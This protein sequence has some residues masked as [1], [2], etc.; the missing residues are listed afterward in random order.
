MT[1]EDTINL[2][3]ENSDELIVATE[4]G[5]AA[6]VGKN[7]EGRKVKISTKEYPNIIGIDEDEITTTG[8]TLRSIAADNG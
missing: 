6:A 4:N 3:E 1:G 7:A 8:A 5:Y 2:N